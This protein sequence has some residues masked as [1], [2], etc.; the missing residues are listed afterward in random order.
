MLIDF[1]KF[2]GLAP[3]D[4]ERTA[5]VSRAVECTNVLLR[6]GDIR[7]LP[8]PVVT[9]LSTD[10]GATKLLEDST[11]G[12]ILAGSYGDG[13]VID[14]FRAGGLVYATLHGSPVLMQNGAVVGA[15]FPER[16]TTAP[17]IVQ[18]ANLLG[19]QYAVGDELANIS[20]IDTP[21]NQASTGDPAFIAFQRLSGTVGYEYPTATIMHAVL[22]VLNTYTASYQDPT[23]GTF[24]FRQ[25]LDNMRT[26]ITTQSQFTRIWNVSDSLQ[27]VMDTPYA[28]G[29]ATLRA[30]YALAVSV[31]VEWVYWELTHTHANGTYPTAMPY[32][33]IFLESPESS[34]MSW[35]LNLVQQMTVTAPMVGT[36][37]QGA[38]VALKIDAD[39]S[40]IV[41]LGSYVAATWM[42]NA[43]VGETASDTLYRVINLSCAEAEAARADASYVW[44]GLYGTS[45]TGAT[46]LQ[47]FTKSP[48]ALLSH[49]ESYAAPVPRAYCY[50]WI[51]QWGRESRPSEPLVV[52]GQGDIGSAAIHTVY[53]P[54]VP[55]TV[56]PLVAIYRMVTPHGAVDNEALK[57]VWALAAL[58]EPSEALAGVLVDNVGD[59]SYA[60]LSTLADEPHPD[61]PRFLGRTEAGHAVCTDIAG[62]TLYVSKR[63]TFWSYPFNRRITLPAGTHVENIVITGDTLFVL[64]DDYPIVMLIGEDKGDDGLQ[65]EEHHLTH[66]AF[67]C[68]GRSA[69]STGWGVMYW[70]S[71]GLIAISGVNVTV[72]SI[73]LVDD[74]QVDAYAADRAAAY[75]NGMYYGFRHDGVCY[76]FDVPDPVFGEVVK[77]PLTAATVGANAALVTQAGDMLLATGD[78][79]LSLWDWNTVPTHAMQY[80]TFFQRVPSTAMFTAVKVQGAGVSGILECYD[81]TGLRWSRAVEGDRPYRV[82]ATRL[83]NAVSLRYVGQGE[84]ITAIEIASSM[85]ELGSV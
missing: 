66:A 67:G 77:A 18:D 47:P 45:L 79:V 14:E 82:P 19:G 49:Q 32:V 38:G 61:V 7:P 5:T 68:V 83:R 54:D 73:T 16:P 30:Q 53:C 23:L 74:D 22:V 9:A 58:V 11:V 40:W 24:T 55:P 8:L 52:T 57:P 69:V 21:V 34:A 2:S 4:G 63:H 78:S 41:T 56:V 29:E 10:T 33:P 84:Y 76:M 42:E 59:A 62:T 36:Y 35:T 39:K 44:V 25:L 70:G 31:F 13:L 3:I 43:S 17:Y 12:T 64:T 60:A 28:D 37:L 6:K 1:S 75:Q 71:V 81:A 48:T 15:L 46:A 85:L 20:V 26:A 51:D 27:S 50:T 65:V 72:A 80:Q